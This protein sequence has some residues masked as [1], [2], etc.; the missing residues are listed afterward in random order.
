MQRDKLAAELFPTPK[1]CRLNEKPSS[2]K[3]EPL[4]MDGQANTPQPQPQGYR[5]IR[6]MSGIP[7]Q[8]PQLRNGYPAPSIWPLDQNPLPH[9]RTRSPDR[10]YEGYYPGYSHFYPPPPSHKQQDGNDQGPKSPIPPAAANPGCEYEWRGYTD[11]YPYPP[12]NHDGYHSSYH[13]PMMHN[14]DMHNCDTYNRD[15]SAGYHGP[16]R[17]PYPPYKRHP[18]AVDLGMNTHDRGEELYRG[19]ELSKPEK[20]YVTAR[21]D[22]AG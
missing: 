9:S 5:E 15:P 3:Q 7:Q 20:V 14:R 12:Y 17:P 16:P 21:D 6:E 18:S 4:P 8:P 22:R 19:Q 13:D 10:L 11:P 2:S 1:K